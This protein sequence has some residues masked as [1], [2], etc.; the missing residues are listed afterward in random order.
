LFDRLR[1]KKKEESAYTEKVNF[2]STPG[3]FEHR[4]FHEKKLFKNE[5]KKS[6]STSPAPSEDK[7]EPY[8]VNKREK[9]K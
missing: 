3:T 4:E 7:W 8:H 6:K 1:K 5:H 2:Y 9:K